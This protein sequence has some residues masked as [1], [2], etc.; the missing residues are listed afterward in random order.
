[1]TFSNKIKTIDDKIEQNKAHYNLGRQA[2]KILTF[3]HEMLVNMNL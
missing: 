3:H 1:M 2:T